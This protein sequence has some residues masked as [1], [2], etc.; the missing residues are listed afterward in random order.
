MALQIQQKYTEMRS[1]IPVD[2][3]TSQAASF[4]GST[5]EKADT[6]PPA[7]A[8]G[9]RCPSAD[10]VVAAGGVGLPASPQLVPA[11]IPGV[12]KTIAISPIAIVDAQ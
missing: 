1:I 2:W 9:M 7:L 5:P 12:E 4:P 8:G 6:R 10:E 11:T 3:R